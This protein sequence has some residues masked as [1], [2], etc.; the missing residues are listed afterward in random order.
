[1]PTSNRDGVTA[2]NC[3]SLLKVKLAPKTLEGLNK[4]LV[5]SNAVTAVPAGTRPSN[6]M[7]CAATSDVKDSNK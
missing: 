6:W 5:A 2:G 4:P 7:F 1:M 3:K